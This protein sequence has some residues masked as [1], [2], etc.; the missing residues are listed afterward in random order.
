MNLDLQA[1][2]ASVPRRRAAI[3]G[4]IVVAL[5]VTFLLGRAIGAR[6]GLAALAGGD[7]AQHAGALELRNRESAKKLARLETDAKIDREAYA[8]I[9][10]Q[11]TELQGKLIEQQE[12]VAFYRGIIGGSAEGGLKV[13]DFSLTAAG[14]AQV[15]LRFVLAQTERSERDVNGQVQLRVEGTR[16]GRLVS[17]DVATLVG[18]R[19]TPLTFG[20]RYFQEMALDLKLPAGFLPERVV[21][22]V[23]PTTRGIKSS[24]ESFPWTVPAG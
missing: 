20:F 9:E 21:L 17:L 23:L 6:T 1:L 8:Q 13:Q 3:V 22:R 19:G 14:D 12:E 2:L 5:L 24:V 10:Q 16:E 18:G 11:L 4:A 15:K 7:L